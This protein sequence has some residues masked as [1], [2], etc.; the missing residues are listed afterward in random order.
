MGNDPDVRND[1]S[2]PADRVNLAADALHIAEEAIVGHVAPREGALV[3]VCRRGDEWEVEWALPPGQGRGPDF[4]ARVAIDAR[5]GAV[6][7][8]LAGS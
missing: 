8:I 6:T 1:A 7:S 4:E 2:V 3:S 5:T